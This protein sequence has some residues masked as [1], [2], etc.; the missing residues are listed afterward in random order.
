M[1]RVLPEAQE[2]MD[3]SARERAPFLVVPWIL[4]AAFL[5]CAGWGLSLIHQLNA[6]GYAVAIGVA[7]GLSWWNRS[8]FDAGRIRFGRFRR[9]FP[10]CFLALAVLATLGG[11]LHPP[12]NYDGLTYRI[13]RV[14]H[15]LAE[16]GWHWIHS[17]F[18]RLNVRSAGWEWL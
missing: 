5:Q 8:L 10:C 12:A 18:H 6:L 1:R 11:V 17:S 2:S 13:P 9:V 15:W 14:L 4:L 16:G 7:T 3:S